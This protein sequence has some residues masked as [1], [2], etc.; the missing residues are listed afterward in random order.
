MS[1]GENAMSEVIDIYSLPSAPAGTR[2][3]YARGNL[4]DKRYQRTILLQKK[5][6]VPMDLTEEMDAANV[7][8]E[9]YEHG[10]VTLVQERR[11]HDDF[12][13]IAVRC[14]RR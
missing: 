14:A 7:A 12:S 3:E 1:K 11:G 6:D 5:C 8:W 13:Y 4:A 2:A 10:L 9:M